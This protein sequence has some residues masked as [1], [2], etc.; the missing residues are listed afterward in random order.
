ML[1]FLEL[2]LTAEQ[3][4]LAHRFARLALHPQLQIQHH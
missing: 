1:D 2:A 4:V 3:E